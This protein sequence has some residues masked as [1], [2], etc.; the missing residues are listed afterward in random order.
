MKTPRRDRSF[1][2]RNF[3]TILVT[4]FLVSLVLYLVLVGIP[5]MDKRSAIKR[6]DDET[7]IEGQRILEEMLVEIKKLRMAVEKLG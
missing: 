7:K 2:E 4:A 6:Q 5:E 3:H 1:I